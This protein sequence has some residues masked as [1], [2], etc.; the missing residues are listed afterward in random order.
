MALTTRNRAQSHPGPI[1]DETL[2]GNGYFTGFGYHHDTGQPITVNEWLDKLAPQATAVLAVGTCASFGGIH[3]MAGIP[4]VCVPS[5]PSKPDNLSE[6]LLY[7]LN[8]IVGHAPMIPLDE[9]LRPQ[10][11]FT[12]TVHESCQ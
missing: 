6:V 4:I 10:W 7:L 3:S 5:C 8:Q 1:P 11:L 9:H 12:S 2:S